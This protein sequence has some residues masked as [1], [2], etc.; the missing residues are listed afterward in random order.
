VQE[1][2]LKCSKSQEIIAA[3]I[4]WATAIANHAHME[5][6]ALVGPSGHVPTTM[7]EQLLQA[8]VTANGKVND[9][10]KAYNDFER[11]STS[12]REEVELP[13]RNQV[14]HRPDHSASI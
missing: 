12:E 11:M 4:D 9:A 5:Q 3:Q 6:L 2:R 8:L 10:L 14:K 7:E 13:E 1:F